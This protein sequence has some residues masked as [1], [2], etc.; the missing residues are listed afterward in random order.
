MNPIQRLRNRR[1]HNRAADEHH[2][3]WAMR[4][5]CYNFGYNIG[6]AASVRPGRM[7]PALSRLIAQG[8]VEDGW[9]QTAPG[10]PSRRW[11]R[12]TSHDRDQSAPKL[13]R[14]PPAAT[15]DFPL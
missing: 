12:L 11:Y 2:V 10:H 13:L 1:D 3:L 6:L 9:G 14:S 5:G 7:Y 15:G 8:L 4:G